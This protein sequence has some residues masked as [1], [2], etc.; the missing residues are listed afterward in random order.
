MQF[1]PCL[2]RPWLSLPPRT[3]PHSL[4]PVSST[5]LLPPISFAP[6]STPSPLPRSLH[7]V[8]SS[9]SP[10]TPFHPPFA[11]LLDPNVYPSM[12][13]AESSDHKTAHKMD[14]ETKHK[15][16]VRCRWNTQR[17][18]SKALLPYTAFVQKYK[19]KK[20]KAQYGNFNHFA[21]KSN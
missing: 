18:R 8:P 16:C 6:S 21:F 12:Q 20:K 1:S 2:V 9:Q 7:S 11:P 15:H 4:H 13:H 3:P 19:K 14:C 17:T 5:P 10:S